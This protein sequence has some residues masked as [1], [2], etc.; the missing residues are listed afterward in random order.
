[1]PI[2]D[3]LFHQLKSLIVGSVRKYI[4]QI[5]EDGII[6]Y[7]T[8]NFPL[9]DA[10]ILEHLQGKKTVGG[11]YCNG[12]SK[13]LCFD[14]DCRD[15]NVTI[16]LKEIL[17]QNK[18]PSQHIHIEDSGNKGWHIWIFFGNT[19]P[20][21][22]LVD[23]G[24]YVKDKLWQDKRNIELRPE[25]L[26]SKGIKFPLG[27]QKKTNRKTEFVNHNLEPLADPNQYFLNIEPMPYLEMKKIM[28]EARKNYEV[29]TVSKTV[30]TPLSPLTESINSVKGKAE[31]ITNNGIAEYIDY[32]DKKKRHYLQFFVILYYKQQGL[33]KEE[34]TK[35]VIQWALRQ[36]ALGFSGSSE[37]E[38]IID[39]KL[40]VEGI[41]KSNQKKLFED[42]A[43]TLVI[44]KG[45]ILVTLTFLTLIER[46]VF[47]AILMLG[48]MYHIEGQF[49]FSQRKIIQMTGVSKSSV[50][51]TI[52]QLINEDY[53]EL[54]EVGSYSDFK[55]SLYKMPYL[56]EKTIPLDIKIDVLSFQEI[57]DYSF[58]LTRNLNLM[59]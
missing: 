42:S 30:V 39:V 23:F 38:L 26:T 24:N 3:Q 28:S 52:K 56:L 59:I 19:L 29:K 51:R 32:E 36:K 6:T 11:F 41:M 8:R 13:F 15:P 46:K 10:V 53:L 25:S 31:K 21:Q 34:I 5:E 54:I 57:F 4:E 33:S 35:K 18:I 37:Q 55:A 44:Y 49:F 40:D 16:A 58:P 17:L 48:R 14:I 7:T 27:I 22:S 47:W 43:R 20:I 12:G 1:M 45:D 9:K 50:H 2:E